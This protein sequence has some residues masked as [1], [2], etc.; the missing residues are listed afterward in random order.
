MLLGGIL[1]G[2]VF[3]LAFILWAISRK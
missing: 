2:I 3:L 1:I